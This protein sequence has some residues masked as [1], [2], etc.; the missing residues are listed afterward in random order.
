MSESSLVVHS[1]HD[2]TK[3]KGRQSKEEERLVHTAYLMYSYVFNISV[4]QS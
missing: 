4:K 2:T 1:G 3:T